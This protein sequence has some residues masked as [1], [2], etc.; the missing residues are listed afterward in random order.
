MESVDELYRACVFATSI[1]ILSREKKIHNVIY[2]PVCSAWMVLWL[3]ME[4]VLC[5]L[6]SL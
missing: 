1:S 5:W 2:V 3:L 6:Y 4:F